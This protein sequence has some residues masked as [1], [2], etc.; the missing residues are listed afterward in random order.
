MENQ[1]PTSEELQTYKKVNSYFDKKIDNN[2]GRFSILPK[3]K[4]FLVVAIA[5]IAFLCY[6]ALTTLI[7]GQDFWVQSITGLANR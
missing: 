4:W 5:A 7:F 3:S 1:L 6:Y 2:D